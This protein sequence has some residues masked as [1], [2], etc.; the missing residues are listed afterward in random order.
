MHRIV[1]ALV[2]CLLLVACGEEQAS[3]PGDGQLI[4]W[5]P[6]FDSFDVK[7]C[8]LD[9]TIGTAGQI[10]VDAEDRVYVASAR[11]ELMSE[12]GATRPPSAQRASLLP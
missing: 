2:A 10:W 1:L 5:F 3:G 7:Y 12:P 8:K 6:P 9:V 4:L 11:V